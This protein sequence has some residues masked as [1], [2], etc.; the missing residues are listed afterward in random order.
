M[1]QQQQM[2]IQQQQQLP[3]M[4]QA[5]MQAVPQQQYV[6]AG[7]PVQ[8][9][10]GS[11]QPLVV[12][13]PQP[14][15]TQLILNQP[16]GVVPQPQAQLSNQPILYTNSQNSFLQQQQQPGGGSGMVVQQHQQPAQ[17]ATQQQQQQQQQPVSGVVL[18]QP[19]VQLVAGSQPQV[20][21][22][23]IYS[24]GEPLMAPTPAIFSAPTPAP[25]VVNTSVPMSSSTNYTFDP[26]GLT[27][28]QQLAYA[29]AQQQHQQQHLKKMRQRL[30]HVS[31]RELQSLHKQIKD[32]QHKQHLQTLQTLRLAQVQE[33]QAFKY[34]DTAL[35]NRQKNTYH[36]VGF[37]LKGGKSGSP[38]MSRKFDGP[39]VHSHVPAAALLHEAKLVGTPDTLSES[40]SVKSGRSRSRTLPFLPPEEPAPLPSQTK[41]PQDRI[42]SNRRAY[43]NF[44]QSSLDGLTSRGYGGLSRPRPSNSETNLRK[45]A[46]EERNRPTS[47]LGLLQAS[48]VVSSHGPSAA[49]KEHEKRILENILPPDLR[50]LIRGGTSAYN[51]IQQIESSLRS[52]EKSGP[53]DAEIAR[54]N[55]EKRLFGGQ[56]E[57]IVA[58]MQRYATMKDPRFRAEMKHKLNPVLDA[59]LNRNRQR[60]G[61]HRRNFSDG[62]ISSTVT[63]HL[64]DDVG[65]A[66]SMPNRPYS[67]MS[68]GYG[69][70]PRP[71]AHDPLGLDN[72]QSYLG[73]EGGGGMGS[74]LRDTAI[75]GYDN[76]DSNRARFLA[77]HSRHLHRRA[78]AGGL[79][80][81]YH[82]MNNQDFDGFN[83]SPL[84]SRRPHSSMSGK[85]GTRSWHPSPFGSDDETE[86][87]HF[88]K[89]EKKNRIKMEISRRRHQIEENA[90]LHEELIRLAKLRESAE[91]G[92][93]SH[94]L[95]IAGY[96]S[97][98]ISP[99]REGNSVLRSVDEIP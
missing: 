26:S 6:Q 46:L 87:H 77:S 58:E 24:S 64:G 78:S 31:G 63:D 17:Q 49:A 35:K 72:S 97:P 55:A 30:P 95:G 94:R 44:R 7:Q 82:Q 66:S 52:S 47:A 5:V 28:A 76:D 89:E 32:L 10:V 3:M 40:G 91:L 9:L 11:Q 57:R 38:H 39:S 81:T 99:G 67:S 4:Q 92:A 19:G 86:E 62:R 25:L 90:R 53:S 71:L 33:K 61:G 68:G 37:H 42:N 45:L 50:H 56:R 85:L 8:Q 74:V 20:Q 88:F 69:G 79:E 2:P 41:K 75:S 43:A 80:N 22:V 98:S 70:G 93:D 18:T 14:M 60:R 48:S 15:G 59:Q 29:Q 27:P 83:A 13:Q 96:P 36:R 84:T 1:Q 73:V 23:V 16:Q 65:Y 34:L 12:A 54:L 21:P 51:S